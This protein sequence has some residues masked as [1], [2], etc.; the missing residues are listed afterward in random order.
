MTVRNPVHVSDEIWNGEMHTEEPDSRQGSTWKLR[1]ANVG[2]DENLPGSAES[3]S[4]RSQARY[5]PYSFAQFSAVAPPNPH[6]EPFLQAGQIARQRQDLNVPA[7]PEPFS[8]AARR[9]HQ[10]HHDIPASAAHGEMTDRRR[11]WCRARR[12]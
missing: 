4:Q 7:H 2:P 11:R 8:Q 3:A 1:T 6:A 12:F 9:P 10:P 5:Y